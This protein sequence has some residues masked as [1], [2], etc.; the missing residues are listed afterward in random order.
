M[1]IIVTIITKSEFDARLR[2][3]LAQLEGY[4]PEPYA[5]TANPSHPTIGI[6]FDLTVD[7]VRETVFKSMGIMPGMPAFTALTNAINAN[8]GKSTAQVRA[9]LNAAYGQPFFMTSPQIDSKMLL[10]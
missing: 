5:D 7:N 8:I 3:L 6:G 9:A 1:S 10:P 2:N 4:R